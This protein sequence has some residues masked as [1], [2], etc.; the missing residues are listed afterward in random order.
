[1]NML[2]RPVRSSLGAKYVMAVTGLLL[3]GFVLAHM[4]GNLQIFLGKRALNDY[5]RHLEELG[6]L[7]WAAR[8]GLLLIFALH[9]ALGL[10]LA[11]WRRHARPAPYVYEDTMQASWASRHMLLTGLVVFAFVV[12]HLLHFTFGVTDPEHFKRNTL[13]VPEAEY[14]LEGVV[15]REPVMQK[16]YDVAKMVVDG[17]RNAW[18]SL[19]YVLAQIVLGLHLWHGGGSWLQSLGW[20]RR[21]SAWLVN[22]VGP[23]VAAVVVVGNC[24]IPLAILAGFRPS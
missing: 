22:A 18:V 4:A 6:G 15:A 20:N 10:R 1:M 19:A 11:Y 3:I 13:K 23:V 9:V 17:F 5:A 14:P 8:L 2:L 12:Y 16:E 24:S 21:R 7:L